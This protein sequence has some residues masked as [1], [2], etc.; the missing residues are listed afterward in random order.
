MIKSGVHVSLAIRCKI[1]KTYV[2]AT[3]FH[4]SEPSAQ[5]S[6]ADWIALSRSC[7]CFM[8]FHPVQS[9]Q[10]IQPQCAKSNAGYPAAYL[11]ASSQADQGT[12][13]TPD[14]HLHARG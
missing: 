1:N 11:H 2:Q 14:L 9:D 10:Y 3:Y 6:A 8:C 7:H 13:R 5:L 4:S 12:H